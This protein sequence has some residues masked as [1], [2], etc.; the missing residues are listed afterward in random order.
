MSHLNFEF[1]ALYDSTKI[2][3]KI[4]C[5]FKK[6]LI[7]P[8]VKVFPDGETMVFFDDESKNKLACKKVFVI[9][10]IYEPIHLNL[11]NFLLLV[12]ELKRNGVEEV[13]AVF[14]YLSYMRQDKEGGMELVA[15]LLEAAGITS[16]VIAQMHSERITTFFS[17]PFYHVSFESVIADIIKIQLKNI[18]NVSIVAPDKGAKVRAGKVAQIL[19]CDMVLVSKKRTGTNSLKIECVNGCCFEKNMIIVD[20]IIDTS[21]TAIRVCDELLGRGA[22]KVYGFFSHPVFS[23]NGFEKIIESNFEKVF[24]SN[25]IPLKKGESSKIEVFDSVGCIIETIQK[26]I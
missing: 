9:D 23:G 6:D 13:C 17:V 18:D 19:G 22:K 5:H 8:E 12:N 25:T 15:R 4:A 20:D 14:P 11:L 24:V 16:V 26:L 3:S 7:L 2:A 1:V 10:S 21:G